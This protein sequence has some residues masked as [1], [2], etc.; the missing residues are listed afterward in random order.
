[1]RS[2][3]DEPQLR[4]S[5][6]DGIQERREVRRSASPGR[7]NRALAFFSSRMLDISFSQC[8]LFV[9]NEHNKSR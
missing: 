1:M 2:E 3:N 5:L 9:S 4:S 7:K 6:P 8:L